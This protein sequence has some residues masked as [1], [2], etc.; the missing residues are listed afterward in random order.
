MPDKD[1]KEFI[2]EEAKDLNQT[3]LLQVSAFIAG[4]KASKAAGEKMQ[5]AA[6]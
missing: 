2:A 1:T 4:M 3:E 5:Q 6:Q